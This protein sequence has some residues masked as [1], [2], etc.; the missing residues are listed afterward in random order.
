MVYAMDLLMTRKRLVG[1][2]LRPFVLVSSAP[3]K[4]T[5]DVFLLD[6]LEVR[7]GEYRQHARRPD[8]IGE[9]KLMYG[10]M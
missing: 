7:L 1:N 10:V 5:N 8:L 4:R 2:G 6:T 9:G 3:M